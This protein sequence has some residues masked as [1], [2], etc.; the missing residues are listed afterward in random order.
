MWLVFHISGPTV[1][2]VQCI[3]LRRLD[4]N[5]NALRW[6][7]MTGWPS[8]GQTMA[9]ISNR[10]FQRVSLLRFMNHCAERNKNSCFCRL[11]VAS[12][13]VNSSLDRVRT[14]TKTRSF[15]SNAIISSSPPGQRT[16]RAR[17]FISSLRRRCSAA[18]ASP[19]APRLSA[20]PHHFSQFHTFMAIE[21]IPP[22]PVPPISPM[23]G[24]A[25]GKSNV[26]RR[27][28][29][30]AVP[31]TNLRFTP[32]TRSRYEIGE[33]WTPG[34]AEN[35]Q[36]RQQTLTEEQFNEQCVINRI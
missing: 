4:R 34:P 11:T 2:H 18:K 22:K 32:T 23:P 31:R 29:A 35:P 24:I 21:H 8:L 20:T 12:G 9:T 13:V 30:G 7:R 27:H 14:S 15:S 17:I 36:R 25:A 6:W 16:L 26:S 28:R 10:G 3:Y 19:R 1:R 33:R 5:E